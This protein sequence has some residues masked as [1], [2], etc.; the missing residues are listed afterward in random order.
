MNG[1]GVPGALDRKRSRAGCLDPGRTGMRRVRPVVATRNSAKPRVPPDGGPAI[2]IWHL[3][4]LNVV[5]NVPFALVGGLGLVATLRRRDDGSPVFEDPW[6][7]WPYALV[8]LG[9]AVTALGSSYYHLAPDTA[10]LV[11]D[12]LPMTLVCTGL[13]TAVLAECV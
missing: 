6:L 4:R 12:R 2:G 7:R 10:R 11:W 1:Y 13:V 8:F 5:S 9:T 3:E